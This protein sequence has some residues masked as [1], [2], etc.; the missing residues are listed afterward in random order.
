[1]LKLYNIP[2]TALILSSSL[3][4]QHS[5]I[6]SWVVCGPDGRN[7]FSGARSVRTFFQLNGQHIQFNVVSTET[8]RDAQA[9]P[10]RYADLVIR[11]AGFS[12]FFTTVDKALQ[13]DIIARTKHQYVG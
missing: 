1:M 12:A 9:H 2:T 13:E 4:Y 6:Q 5:P 3:L 11:V 7:R 8:L 10:E